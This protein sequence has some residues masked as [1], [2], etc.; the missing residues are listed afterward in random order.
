MAWLYPFSAPAQQ[1]A[2][3]NAD[4]AFVLYKVGKAI[5]RETYTISQLGATY[6]VT[7]HFEFTDRGKKVPLDT[8]FVARTGRMIP[9]SY[10]AKGK[11][12]RFS[13]LDDQVTVDRG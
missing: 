12:S 9:V 1:S 4:S 2:R 11:S 5:G 3:P 7:S 10:L 6:Q 8:K 13:D